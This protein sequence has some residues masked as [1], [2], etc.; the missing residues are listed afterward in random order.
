MWVFKLIEPFS[1]KVDF[2]FNIIS[3]INN[4]DESFKADTTWNELGK[5][6]WTLKEWTKQIN[7]IK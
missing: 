7:G 6:S 5:P 2:Q 3:A 1:A 4:Y